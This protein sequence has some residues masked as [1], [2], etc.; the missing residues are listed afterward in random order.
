MIDS[1][2]S[3]AAAAIL[4]SPGHSP[5]ALAQQPDITPAGTP[6]LDSGAWGSTVSKDQAYLSLL[7]S[8]SLSFPSLRVAAMGGSGSATAERVRNLVR[9]IT[10]SD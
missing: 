2:Q 10:D 3:P 4:S 7:V 5:I 8:L 6:E 9:S 1:G